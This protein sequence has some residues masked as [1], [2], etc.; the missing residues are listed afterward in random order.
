[1]AGVADDVETRLVALEEAVAA[2]SGASSGDRPQ[3]P[4]ATGGEPLWVLTGLEE[5]A[6]GGAV[7]YAGSVQ[8]PA[9]A[10]VRWQYGLPAAQVFAEEWGQ[11]AKV[12]AALGHPVRLRLLGAV[13]R[14]VDTA[15]R[16]VD[17]M[18]AGTSGQVYHHLKDLSSAGWLS[19]PRRGVYA[20]PAA[21]VVPLLAILVAA[22]T[23]A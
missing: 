7:L 5:R 8:T 19:S 9:G 22:G 17:E 11:H 10:V 20:V 6:P 21:R 3:A 2:L 4:P 18:E 1:M 12:L 14:G 15:A 16:L 13:L 23:P